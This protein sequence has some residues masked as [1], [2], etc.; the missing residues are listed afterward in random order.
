MDAQ[1]G[2]TQHRSGEFP[3]NLVVLK[4][5]SALGGQAVGRAAGPAGG[6]ERHRFQKTVNI[7]RSIDRGMAEERMDSHQVLS[8]RN[9]SIHEL[10]CRHDA[11]NL[12]SVATT[13][14]ES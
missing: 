10:Y 9:F 1:M 12:A 3:T 6:G 2:P 4:E 13:L 11:V 5:L 8:G 7:D 14:T